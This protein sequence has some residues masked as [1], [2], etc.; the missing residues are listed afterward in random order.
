MRIPKSFKL[1]GQTVTILWLDVIKG[2]KRNCLGMARGEKNRIEL[3]KPTEDVPPSKME[4]IF[5]HE[6]VHWI[7]SSMGERKL[8]HNE[9][10]VRRFAHGLHQVLSTMEYEEEDYGI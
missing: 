4:M 7:L 6:A 5:W 1:F 9:A 10:F 2:K 3:R 8:S